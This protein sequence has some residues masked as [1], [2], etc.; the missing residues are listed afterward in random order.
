MTANAL[1]EPAEVTAELDLLKVVLRV[2]ADMN[3]QLLNVERGRC[4][5]VDTENRSRPA[6]PSS[7]PDPTAPPRVGRPITTAVETHWADCGPVPEG[8]HGM[9]I[10]V[11]QADRKLRHLLQRRLASGERGAIVWLAGRQRYLRRD[12]FKNA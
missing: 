2:F 4:S 1:P 11:S 6:T 10:W 12:Q 8:T 7:P 3:P 5:D 9:A